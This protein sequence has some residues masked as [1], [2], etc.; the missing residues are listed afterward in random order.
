MKDGADIQAKPF[1][2]LRNLSMSQEVFPSACEVV[3]LK[4][5]FKKGKKTDPSNY[6]PISLLP[7]I[8]KITG[9]VI[10]DQTN[11]LLSDENT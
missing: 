11:A 6:K 9:K 7:V 2:A 5:I 3:K 10:H 8:S 4:P 1:S